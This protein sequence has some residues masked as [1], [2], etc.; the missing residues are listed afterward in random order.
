MRL[1]CAEDLLQ[2]GDERFRPGLTGPGRDK[3]IPLTGIEK[4]AIL[5]PVTLDL[6]RGTGDVRSL[7]TIL[8][9][10]PRRGVALT[11]PRNACLACLSGNLLERRWKEISTRLFRS[12]SLPLILPV[13]Q[14]NES[15]FFP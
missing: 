9:S 2:G 5:N 15:Q 6:E 11:E 3:R 4:A 14:P 7:V 13:C 8:A 10:S 12:K 1:Q